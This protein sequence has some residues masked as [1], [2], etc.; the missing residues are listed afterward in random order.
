MVVVVFPVETS[1]ND[2]ADKVFPDIGCEVNH[3][4][5]FHWSVPFDE[6]ETW[7]SWDT[8]VNQLPNVDGHIIVKC[9][10]ARTSYDMETFVG[11]IAV[12]PE[13]PVAEGHVA[14]RVEVSFPNPTDLTLL[15]QEIE[16]LRQRVSVLE[17]ASN[18]RQKQ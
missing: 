5:E 16:K 13:E 15:Q 3:L 6:D 8:R 10:D 17:D 1:M 11:S 9:K 12:Q 4:M 2:I 14:L 18:K 7:I